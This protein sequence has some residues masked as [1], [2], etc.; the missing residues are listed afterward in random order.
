MIAVG[1][2]LAAFLCGVAAIVLAV[3]V[4]VA[5][6]TD[7]I[8]LLAGAALAAGVGLVLTVAPDR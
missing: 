5:H 8:D 2:R 3:L 7:E 1:P 6:P 4:L